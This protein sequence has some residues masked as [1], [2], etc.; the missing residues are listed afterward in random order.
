MHLSLEGENRVEGRSDLLLEGVDA[1]DLHYFLLRHRIRGLVRFA[2]SFQI[3][4]LVLLFGKDWN[5]SLFRGDLVEVFTEV[6]IGTGKV[7]LVGFEQFLVDFPR[8]IHY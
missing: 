8:I 6:F 3:L 2:S 4:G 1:L 5:L 7:S